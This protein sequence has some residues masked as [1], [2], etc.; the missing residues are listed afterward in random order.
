MSRS[1]WEMQARGPHAR[2]LHR[3]GWRR[4]RPSTRGAGTVPL[5]RRQSGEQ[6]LV[7][8]RPELAVGPHEFRERRGARAQATLQKRY[9]FRGSERFGSPEEQGEALENAR[10]RVPCG[11]ADEERAGAEGFQGEE[12]IAAA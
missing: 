9:E 3:A 8:F 11:A 10:P 1:V 12:E 6:G 4:R 2:S 5:C 7:Y